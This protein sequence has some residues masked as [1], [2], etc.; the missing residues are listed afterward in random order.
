MSR[1]RSKPFEC[2]WG[3]RSRSVRITHGGCQLKVRING[4]GRSL[5]FQVPTHLR[6]DLMITPKWS[7]L[8]CLVK[9]M[10]FC[11]SKSIHKEIKVGLYRLT[12]PR[13][14][15]SLKISLQENLRFGH[16]RRRLFIFKFFLVSVHYRS[17][18]FEHL[19]SKDPLGFGASLAISAACLTLIQGRRTL[20]PSHPQTS[21]SLGLDH[22]RRISSL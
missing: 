18:F 3:I 6:C 10:K 20:E 14:N 9:T 8:R 7:Y 2:G 16:N 11:T 12:N 13:V 4:S 15:F 19:P 5:R 17:L 1:G 22:L 21:W